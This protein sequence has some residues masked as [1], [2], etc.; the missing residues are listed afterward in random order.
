VPPLL[1]AL[2]LPQCNALHLP[3]APHLPNALPL[4]SALANKYKDK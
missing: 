1:L 3:N 2:F 4:L